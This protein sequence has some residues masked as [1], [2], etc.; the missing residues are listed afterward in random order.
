MCGGIRLPVQD[1][2]GT[3]PACV[4]RVN[5]PNGAMCTEQVRNTRPTCALRT[6]KRPYTDSR[7][8]CSLKATTDDDGGRRPRTAV[9]DT[10]RG[11]G[12][13][14]AGPQ[15]RG[16]GDEGR[17]GDVQPD[18]RGNVEWDI[19]TTGKEADVF[20]RSC[21]VRLP[22]RLPT[23]SFLPARPRSPTPAERCTTTVNS[24]T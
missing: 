18:W 3:I 21:G 10:C 4:F 22:R 19:E 23:G 7:Y 20:S 6:E 11:D 14:H 9:R 15:L 17:C 5:H 16:T 8:G 1:W 13:C 24:S 12:G 2:C